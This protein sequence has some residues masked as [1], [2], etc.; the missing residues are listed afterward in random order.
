MCQLISCP[1]CAECWPEALAVCVDD[2]NTQY[3]S[4]AP[5]KRSL[6]GLSPGIVEATIY[7]K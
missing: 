7:L 2:L 3:P 6:G 4:D 1:Q 5:I